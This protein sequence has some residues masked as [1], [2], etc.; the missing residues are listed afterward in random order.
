MT[1]LKLKAIGL[2]FATLVWLF[3]SLYAI[4]FS[5]IYPFPPPN[6]THTSPTSFEVILHWISNDTYYCVLIPLTIPMLMLVI[7]V[8]WVGKELFRYNE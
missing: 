1:L 2:F 3:T 6:E 7:Y 8:S 5:K 4:V